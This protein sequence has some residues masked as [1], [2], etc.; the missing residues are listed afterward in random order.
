M[1]M[2]KCQQL[3]GSKKHVF[4]PRMLLQLVELLVAAHSSQRV[5]CWVACFRSLLLL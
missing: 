4:L 5:R 3:Q 2:S 1:V